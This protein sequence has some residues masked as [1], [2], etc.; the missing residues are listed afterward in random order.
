MFWVFHPFNA[1]AAA[2][3]EIVVARIY[4]ARII[5]IQ[6]PRALQTENIDGFITHLND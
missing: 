3:R 4:Y 5:E 1:I 2:T 6:R